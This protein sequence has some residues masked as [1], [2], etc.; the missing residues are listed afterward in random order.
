ML[1]FLIFIILLTGCLQN[2]E[3]TSTTSSSTTAPTV[4]LTTTS[5]SSTSVTSTTEEPYWMRYI[6]DG[7]LSYNLSTNTSLLPSNTSNITINQSNSS[8]LK[9]GPTGHVTCYNASVCG[10]ARVEYGCEREYVEIG[11]NIY[12]GELIKKYVY[13]PICRYPGTNRSF[14]EE[15]GPVVSVEENCWR[16]EKVCDINHDECTIPK[17]GTYLNFV[18]KRYELKCECGNGKMEAG[19]FGCDEECEPPDEEDNKYCPQAVEGCEGH[20]YWKRPDDKGRC[21]Q[22]CTCDLDK[23]IYQCLN[24]E[25]GAECGGNG[26]CDDGDP[27]TVDKC[28]DD[29]M[30]EHTS[31]EA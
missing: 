2:E 30:C 1:L 8:A 3:Q 28:S 26:D 31:V 21:S 24:Y 10:K 15:W 16:Q 7:N 11:Q 6:R 14:C 17:G 4:L 13:Y 19:N 22:S 18:Q 20:R 23:K 25:C 9:E 5:T 12:E 27:D 29:C